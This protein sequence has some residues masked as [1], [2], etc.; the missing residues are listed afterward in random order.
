LELRNK[1]EAR[2]APKS[3]NRVKTVIITVINTAFKTLISEPAE[4]V[5][6]MARRKEQERDKT[7]KI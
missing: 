7:I 2:I 5:T 3:A 6:A 4:I 1:K